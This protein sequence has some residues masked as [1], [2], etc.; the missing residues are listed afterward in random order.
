MCELTTAVKTCTFKKL[1]ANC[2]ALC[3]LSICMDHYSITTTT[4][5][6]NHM[7]DFLYSS[8]HLCGILGCLATQTLLM[9][10]KFGHAFSTICFLFYFQS[11]THHLQPIEEF[12]TT[13]K[14]VIAQKWL[15]I[16][17]SDETCTQCSRYIIYQVKA[18]LWVNTVNNKFELIY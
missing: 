12:S 4:T 16:A 14:V 11:S 3:K 8:S 13:F 5:N 9:N 10:Q 15:I 7:K 1:R 18:R 17:K 2:I 6:C